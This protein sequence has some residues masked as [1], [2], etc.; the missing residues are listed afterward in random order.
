MGFLY[1]DRIG[2]NYDEGGRLTMTCKQVKRG[3]IFLMNFH[4]FNNHLIC[5]KRPCVVVSNDIANRSSQTI[6][7]VPLT[8][9]KKKALPTHVAVIG[10]G[11]MKPLSLI[12]I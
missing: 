11:L 10:Y 7:V 5:G 1:E 3:D 4:N 6:T 9:K 12:H 2:K 8:S